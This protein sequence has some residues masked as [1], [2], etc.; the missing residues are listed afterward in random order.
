MKCVKCG[1]EL[2]QGCLYCSV[3][4]HESQILP[5][6]SL[7]EDDYLRSLLQ[8]EPKP[9]TAEE[10][11]DTPPEKKQGKKKKISHLILI[12]FSCLLLIGIGIGIGVKL[13]VDEQN[14]NSYDYQMEMAEKERAEGNYAEA[15]DFYNAALDIKPED[16]AAR[17]AMADIYMKQ[18][19]Y[20]S[21][22]ILLIEIIKADAAD[23]DAYEKLISIYESREDYDSILALADDVTNPEILV[24]FQPY[25]VMPP[26]V[27][28]L[29]GTYE[30]ELVVGLFSTK[31][32][33]IYYTL[34]GTVPD[35]LN[36]LLYRGTEL[37]F[38]KAGE[39]QLKAVCV[40]DKGI[41]SELVEETYQ[42][43]EK[44]P[45]LPTLTPDGGEIW[46][47]TYVTIT[48]EEGCSIYY[49]WDGTD[50]TE[51]SAR[52]TEPIYV[53]EGENVLSVLVVNDRNGLKS[54]IYRSSYSYIL[55]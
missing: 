23:K 19:N 1:A 22:M 36:G 12:V 51:Q 2:K 48:A 7:L 14:A 10:K 5:D 39:Y 41:Y 47:E 37:K 21:A 42:V 52:Y 38:S 25:L 4:G 17:A 44:T 34:D 46:G 6:Y 18:Q 20:D 3:C 26:V 24:L 53:P 40:N 30:G 29:G 55:Q 11:Q 16:L 15:L 13:Y 31:G 35:T 45:D 32:Y 54:D 50:P 9:E 8:E 27:S 28:P 33:D 49:T 43:R